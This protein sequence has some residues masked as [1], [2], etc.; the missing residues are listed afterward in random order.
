MLKATGTEQWLHSGRARSHHPAVGLDHVVVLG[1]MNDETTIEIEVARVEQ[2]ALAKRVEHEGARVGV[3]VGVGEDRLS[4][5]SAAERR[6][7][8]VLPE[9]H[10][11][12]LVFVP[13]AT[14]DRHAAFFVDSRG[15]ACGRPRS[16]A[17]TKP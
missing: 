6:R 11:D 16:P 17:A 8:V 3:L 2:Q 9:H 7:D 10:R 15:R 4:V 13:A 12:D 1:T 14:E 5:R